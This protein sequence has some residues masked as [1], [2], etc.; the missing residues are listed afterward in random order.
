MSAY[1]PQ[2]Y[3]CSCTQAS[4]VEGTSWTRA[5]RTWRNLRRR[6]AEVRKTRRTTHYGAACTNRSSDTLVCRTVS[7]S[8]WKVWKRSTIAVLQ[9]NPHRLHSSLSVQLLICLLDRCRVFVSTAC[10]D[11]A[12]SS[13]KWLSRLDSCNWLSQVKA[14]LCCACVVAQCIDK[15]GSAV[16]CL[17]LILLKTKVWCSSYMYIWSQELQ[18]SCTARKVA[19]AHCK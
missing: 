1:I 4:A 10:T 6:R 11:T 5:N 14:V 8:C 17:H 15:E 9:W 7:A 2:V 18:S 19:T 16:E 13:D 12:S 3:C